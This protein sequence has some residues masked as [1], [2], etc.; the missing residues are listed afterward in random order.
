M[1]AD[2]DHDNDEESYAT[3]SESHVVVLKALV[4]VVERLDT[5]SMVALILA[6]NHLYVH[7]STLSFFYFCLIS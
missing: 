1:I 4:A 5:Q 6:G 7:L 2:M 3:D